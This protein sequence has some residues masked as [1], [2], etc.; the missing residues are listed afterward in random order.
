MSTKISSYFHESGKSSADIY[1][2]DGTYE[3]RYTDSSGQVFH[4]ESFA[5]KSIH[6]VESAAENWALGIKVLNG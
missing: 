6:Y 3:I 5:G 2:V 4:T 1:K